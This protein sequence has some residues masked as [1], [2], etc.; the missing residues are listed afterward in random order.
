MQNPQNRTGVSFS[1][2]YE[3]NLVRPRLSLVLE[4][5]TTKG[6]AILTLKSQGKSV[7]SIDL[8][9]EAMI[10]KTEVPRTEVLSVPSRMP[11]GT[12]YR[13]AA[14]C[15]SSSTGINSIDVKCHL[16][17]RGFSSLSRDYWL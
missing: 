13:K 5:E 9:G 16:D 4:P 12:W 10:T 7:K 11:P 3:T 8:S 6:E 15:A 17:D 2:K 14:S 1:R